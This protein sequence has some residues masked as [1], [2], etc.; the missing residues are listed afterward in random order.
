M[1]LFSVIA[2]LGLLSCVLLR[3][4]TADDK[5]A[6][7]TG[8]ANQPGQ[9]NKGARFDAQRFVK[10]H[11]KNNDGKLSKNELPAEMQDAFKDVDANNDGFISVQELQTHADHMIRQRP[12]MVEVIFYA[13]DVPEPEGASIQELQQ[14]YDVLRKLDKN[15]D[16]KIDQSEVSAF[17]DQRRKERIDRIFKYMDKNNDGK[18]SKDEARGLWQDNF[19]S[20]DANKDGSLERT[21]VE[22][23]LTT[24]TRTNNNTQPNKPQK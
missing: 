21:E 18:I 14:T 12:Q 15:N 9:N 24:P 6:P 22:K 23:A 20:L 3:S 10:D 17:R 2:A 4:G 8:N 16:G 11:D 1:R 13:I 7:A 5:N 19:T